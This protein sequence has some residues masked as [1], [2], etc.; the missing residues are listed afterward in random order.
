MVGGVTTD[1]VRLNGKL[2]ELQSRSPDPMIYFV[3]KAKPGG[4]GEST[5]LTATPNR[6]DIIRPAREECMVIVVYRVMRDGGLDDF[7]RHL[8]F[9]ETSR[10]V[11]VVKAS[12]R[13]HADRGSACVCPVCYTPNL[14]L[15]GAHSAMTMKRIPV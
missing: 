12:R 15:H 5:L 8:L 13:C 1:A 14:H 3:P 6:L 7:R 9:L 2:K 10:C 11:C 4:G